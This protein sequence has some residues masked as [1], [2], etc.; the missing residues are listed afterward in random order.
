MTKAIR[1]AQVFCI[2]LILALAGIAQAQGNNGRGKCMEP[3]GVSF[4]EV[5]PGFEDEWLE[6]YMTWHYPLMEYAL[7]HGALLRHKLFVPAG[8]GMEGAWTF[9]VSFLYPATQDAKVAPL[10]RAVQIK[11]LFGAR[12]NGYVAG[13]KRR[14]QITLRHWDTDFI[15]LDKSEKPLSVYLPSAGGCK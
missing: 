3:F 12:M 2:F 11:K 9:A 4:Y 6:L 13:E 8:H 10:D 5:A 7:E 14:W 1:N 15:E